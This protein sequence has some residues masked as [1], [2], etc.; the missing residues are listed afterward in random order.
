MNILKSP[1][2]LLKARSCAAL[3]FA[4]PLAFLTTAGQAQQPMTDYVRKPGVTYANSNL[5]SAP[6]G[7]E[8]KAGGGSSRAEP[9]AEGKA[10]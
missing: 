10:P 8:S 5:P 2:R 9:G 4:A 6:T 3:V 1:V 7:P